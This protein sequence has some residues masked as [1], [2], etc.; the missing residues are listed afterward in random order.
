[1][2]ADKANAAIF[3]SSGTYTSDAAEFAQGRPIRLIDG[4]ELA[5]MVASIP[6]E[7]VIERRLAKVLAPSQVT[8]QTAQ[9]CPVCGSG[10]VRRVA[11]RGHSAGQSFW[12][13][14]QYPPCKGMRPM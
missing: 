4:E 2:H 3:V 13:C 11:K 5:G 10:M 9:T 7:R 8:S 14:S 1:M 6:E 12:G